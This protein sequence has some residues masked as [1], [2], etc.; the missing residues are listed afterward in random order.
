MTLRLLWGVFR[1]RKMDGDTEEI[2]IT[3]KLDQSTY[4]C[5][6]A[7][8]LIW[9]TRGEMRLGSQAHPHV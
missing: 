7:L 9:R 5:E 6:A 8:W 2:P 4:V 1:V 3:M